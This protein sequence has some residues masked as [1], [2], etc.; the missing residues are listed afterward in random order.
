MQEISIYQTQEI[1]ID[2]WSDIELSDSEIDLDLLNPTI[3][4]DSAE[5]L[6]EIPP[7]TQFAL[8]S[9]QILNIMLQCNYCERQFSNKTARALHQKHCDNNEFKHMLPQ[10][11][12]NY[13]ERQFSNKTARAL[14]HKH[15]DKNK[16]RELNIYE[17]N[18]CKR[19]FNTV[20][21]QKLHHC[22][23]LK[24]PPVSAQCNQCK[25]KFI[26]PSALK[27]HQKYCGKL[28]NYRCTFCNFVT[29]SKMFKDAHSLKCKNRPVFK[30]S[31][32]FQQFTY[33]SKLCQHICICKS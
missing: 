33:F 26:G 29:N 1:D 3:A 9:T 31:V 11:Q 20:T 15:C 28:K 18:Y 8:K 24:K 21:A 10:W 19:L 13:C 17:C 23:K 22:A 12:C 27:K 30:C 32:C 25:Q 4:F 16:F 7:P 5:N 6:C 2:Q 14:H